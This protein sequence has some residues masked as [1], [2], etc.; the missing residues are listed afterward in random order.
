MNCLQRGSFSNNWKKSNVVPIHKKSDKQLLQNYQPVS[1]LPICGKI[2]ERIIF[3]PVLEYLKKNS[4]LCPNQSGFRPFDS[5]ENQLLSIVL[6]VL[7][8][9]NIQLSK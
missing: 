1:L 5:C 3:T 9:I 6:D 8:L 7:V 2:F 4:L